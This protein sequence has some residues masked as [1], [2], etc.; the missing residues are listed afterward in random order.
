MSAFYAALN[1]DTTKC[2]Y[3]D[4]KAGISVVASD[5]GPWRTRHL[6]IRAH[7]LREV[8][9]D[10]EAPWAIRHLSG[11][12]LIAD[13]F[14]KVLTHQAFLKFK[15]RLRMESHHQV[16][17]SAVKSVS[18]NFGNPV[19]WIDPMVAL[20]C[21]GTL[22]CLVGFRDLG[23]LLI[24]CA[25]LA[26]GWKGRRPKKAEEQ[27]PQKMAKIPEESHTPQ[28]ES[29]SGT[30][31]LGSD[32]GVTIRGDPWD[33]CSVVGLTPGIRAFRVESSKSHGASKGDEVK[34]ERSSRSTAAARGRDAVAAMTSRL[35]T[36]NL[37]V[38]VTVTVTEKEE[39]P[40]SQLRG[41]SQH[42]KEA[43]E[44]QKKAADGYVKK[45]PGLSLEG[46]SAT[47]V[48][49]GPWDQHV[50]SQPP[51]GADAWILDYVKEGWLL[52]KHGS[53]GRVRPFH[54][55][56][57]SCPINAVEMTGKRVSIV[58][59]PPSMTRELLVDDWQLPRTWQRPGPWRGFT[60]FE[61][62]KSDEKAP[63]TIYGSADVSG[64]QGSSTGSAEAS[65]RVSR[66]P[67]DG[68]HSYI[69]VDDDENTD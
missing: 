37:A 64:A 46:E 23:T 21:V 15:S 45:P 20:A 36:L 26:I 31:P 47:T 39:L 30:A 12:L 57:R 18:V 41:S 3:G 55:L 32:D 42:R 11:S 5:C 60:F 16:V 4:S 8:V 65:H 17:G 29:W 7:K 24:G 22:L 9:Q 35:E 69:L 54:P 13:G 49:S 40:E 43:R 50:F 25:A 66:I 6:R 33:Q 38:D 63:A 48:G 62:T 58:F 52:R 56:H 51:R 68:D 2:L 28:R 14:T 59:G 67:S 34:P 61:L 44:E 10:M 19:G 1:I 27:R 53:K